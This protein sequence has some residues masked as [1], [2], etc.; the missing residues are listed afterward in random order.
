LLLLAIKIDLAKQ[1]VR[2]AELQAFLTGETSFVDISQVKPFKWIP[3]TV[4]TNVLQISKNNLF[5]DL[6]NS[7]NRYEKNWQKWYESSKPEEEILPEPYVKLSN[8]RK[9]ILIKYRKFRLG[10]F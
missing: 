4:W 6:I 1:S 9:L 7:I 10:I 5:F 8:F 2:S 3:D